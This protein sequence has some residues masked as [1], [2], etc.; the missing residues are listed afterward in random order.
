MLLNNAW[1]AMEWLPIREALASLY[2]QE[3]R[4]ADAEAV[5]TELRALVAVADEDHPV[6]I[7]LSR[8]AGAR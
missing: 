1:F 7:R 8:L 2:R 4:V 6:R 5:E 3:G